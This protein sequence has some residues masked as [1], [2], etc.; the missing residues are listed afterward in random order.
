[1]SSIV[2]GQ[3]QLTTTK[4][5]SISL[6]YV[7]GMAI[8]YAVVGVLAGILEVVSKIYFKHHGQLG[9]WHYCL[10]LWLWQCLEFLN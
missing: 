4:A 7:L 1:M 8:S 6:S 5:F 10:W 3:K 2:T 9:L